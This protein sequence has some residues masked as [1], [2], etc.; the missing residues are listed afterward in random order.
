MRE[1][2]IGKMLRERY[3]DFFGSTYLPEAVYAR[4][5][6]ITRAKMSLQLVLAGLFPPVGQQNWN[7]NLAWQPVDTLYD[8]LDADLMFTPQS[9][10]L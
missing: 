4:S 8:P 1:F 2:K 3:D 10:Q 9:C 6:E 7:S 5:T